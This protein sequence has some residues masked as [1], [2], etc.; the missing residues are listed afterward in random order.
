M[1]NNTARYNHQDGIL[2]NSSDHN[3]LEGNVAYNNLLSGINLTSSSWN[4]LFNNTANNNLGN[5][6][7]LNNSSNNSVLNNSAQFN[8][9]NGIFLN[10]SSD[11]NNITENRVCGNWWNGIAINGSDWNDLVNNT[12][13]EN[14]QNGI[15]LTNSNNTL[16]DHNTVRDNLGS[17]ITLNSSYFNTIANNTVVNS[18]QYGIYYN[19]SGNNLVYNNWF[20]NNANVKLDGSNLGNRWNISKSDPYTNIYGGPYLGGNYWAQPN[21]QGWSQIT[22]NRSDGFTEFPFR[23]DQDNIDELPLTNYTPK[24]PVPPNPPKPPVPPNPLIPYPGYISPFPPFPDNE[25]WDS[26]YI[27]DT[28]PGYME[29]CESRNVSITF[30]N[31]GTASWTRL[32]GVV[33]IPQSNCGFT[34]I[35]QHVQLEPGVEIFHGD[36]YTFNFTIIAPCSNTTCNLTARM[37]RYATEKSRGIVFGDTY[38]E[39]IQVSDQMKQAVKV[40]PVNTLKG[41]NSFVSL[42]GSFK[43]TTLLPV[44]SQR[45]VTLPARNESI[46]LRNGAL[47]MNTAGISDFNGP[48]SMAPFSTGVLNTAESRF[49]TN[50]KSQGITIFSLVG[51]VS[52]DSA[53]KGL[54]P[55]ILGN[56][57]TIVANRT[58]VSTKQIAG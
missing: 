3:N 16:L 22:A 11:G 56:Y 2:L 47:G 39:I 41:S 19:G 12:V 46:Y 1:F 17:G 5:G 15:Q 50:P 26:K 9:Q 20:N 31:N 57:N 45:F 14:R 13:C 24:P 51:N 52:T 33:L 34:I 40:L 18:G 23:I 10:Q 42:K 32:K 55:A 8:H 48:H 58:Y 35:P 44:T 4:T 38:W 30:E 27:S 21:G 43:N 53:R 7:S 29:P 25:I 54:K 37:S 36:Q 6:I 49:L 28:V